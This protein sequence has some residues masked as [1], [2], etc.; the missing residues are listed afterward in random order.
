MN[1]GLN[2]AP[3]P[4]HRIFVKSL[5]RLNIPFSDLNTE[6]LRRVK[7][8]AK[9]NYRKLAKRYHPDK[10]YHNHKGTV[11]CNVTKS[12]NR[13]MDLKEMP[14]TLDNMDAVLRATEVPTTENTDIE[15]FRYL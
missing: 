5:A 3:Q 11:F 4:R 10:S 6:S 14:M 8:K 12:Y 2:I 9:K 1:H 7:Q 13:I 15:D